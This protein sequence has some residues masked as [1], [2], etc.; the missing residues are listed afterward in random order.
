MLKLANPTQLS[1]KVFHFCIQ[2]DD[3]RISMSTFLQPIPFP[4][5]ARMP[6]TKR[7]KT[8]VK[9]KFLHLLI[10]ILLKMTNELEKYE[11]IFT[12]I[13]TPM[14]NDERKIVLECLFNEINYRP[15]LFDIVHQISRALFVK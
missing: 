3:W 6:I 11:E 5:Q 7:F 12:L 10:L 15:S 9:I 4:V 1:L 14:I 8:N 2:H 13:L